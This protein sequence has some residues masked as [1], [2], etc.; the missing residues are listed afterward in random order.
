MIN[1]LLKTVRPNYD[2]VIIDCP[3][4][5]GVL[6]VNAMVTSDTIFQKAIISSYSLH[7]SWPCAAMLS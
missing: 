4:S 6:T 2:Y 7:F 1:K 5:V 3:P